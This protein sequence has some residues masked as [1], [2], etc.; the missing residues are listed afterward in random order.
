M[1]A[2]DLICFSSTLSI[3]SPSKSTNKHQIYHFINLKA[4]TTIQLAH[5]KNN[6]F[7]STLLYF[8][9]GP[10][11]RNFQ[12]S[13][14][15]GSA[16]GFDGPSFQLK[17]ASLKSFLLSHD[18]TL[19][20]APPFPKELFKQFMQTCI[21]KV[22]NQALAHVKPR[23]KASDRLFKARNTNLYYGNLQIKCYYSVSNAR[24]ISRLLELKVTSSYFLQPH[25]FVK[26]STFVGSS[27]RTGFSAKKLPFKLG[28]SLISF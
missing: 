16:A 25:Y 24:I 26:K 13:S 8:H 6:K 18:F 15:R 21:E 5:L 23:K 17:I 10:R 9:Y 14:I 4:L 11:Y 22:R 1:T 27:T 20:L 2:R 3:F 7:C 19:A 12:H 28:T